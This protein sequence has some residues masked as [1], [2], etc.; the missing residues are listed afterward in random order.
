MPLLPHTGR[1]HP[2]TRVFLAAMYLLLFAGAATMIYPFL[3]MISGSVKSAVDIQDLS[4]W[5]R[6]LTEDAAL[7]RS[8]VEGLFNESLE[9]CRV[10]YDADARSFQAVEP[11]A[12]PNAKLVAEWDAFRASAGLPDT[13]FL[14]GFVEAH[15]SRTVPEMLRG[16]KEWLRGR[17]GRG[18]AGVNR[19]LGTDF[20]NWNAVFVVA[21]N[22][23]LRLRQAPRDAFSMAF[24]EFKMTQP[25][26]NRVYVS[27]EGVFRHLYLKPQF[28]PDIADY[29]RIHGTAWPDYSAIPLP[30]ACAG[31]AEP[32]RAAWEDFVRRTVNLL[33]VRLDDS[34]APAYRA[35]LAAKYPDL[36]SLNRLYGTS[37]TAFGDIPVPTEPPAAGLPMSDW[38]AFLK[39]WHDPAGGAV[40]AAPVEALRLAGPEFAFR[41]FLERKYGS[42]AALN[43]ACGTEFAS[44]L[45]I[46]IP[47]RDAHYLAFLD[48]RRALR[49]EFALRNYR[50][51]LDYLLWHGRGLV[52]TAIYCGL[53][54]LIALLVNPLAAYALSRH[55][56]PSAYKL[57]LFML[58]TMAFPPIVTQI[59][60][61][62]MLRD[63]KLLNTFAALVLPGMAHGYSIF[64]L[65]GFFDS[66][67]R[68]LYESAELDGAGEWTIF[69]Q[70]TMSLSR[71]I[72]AVIALSAFTA[73]YAN[74]M[75]ALLIC[76][77][78]RM[79]TLMVWLYQLQSRSGQAVIYA[80]LLVAALPTLLIF[81]F[82]QKIILRGIVIPVER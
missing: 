7:Y 68:E 49:I 46:S 30:S 63:A 60:V 58:L 81:L 28:G 11:P 44:F 38:D 13:A 35:F 31:N 69:W 5:P 42:V 20:V 61:F 17:Y 66:L 2:R 77:D 65:K 34:A 36:S 6:Y 3:L 76:Q 74:F 29:N 75:F 32:E 82:C 59:P 45:N 51:V 16:F 47:Q 27:L 55:R 53:S 57:L 71:P 78:E 10:T 80:S 4:L 48:A 15:Q 8:Y 33:W 41:D 25:E 1:R 40:H 24:R 50:T 37:C 70:I 79:W 23:G 54:V 26:R 52:N 14:L 18:I 12:A 22:Y 21:E 9:L 62:L 56:P 39:G 64:L 19:A 43:A 73:A 67:P 72:L